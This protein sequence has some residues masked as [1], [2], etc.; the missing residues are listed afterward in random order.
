MKM[1]A[2]TTRPQDQGNTEDLP[3]L[4]G[5]WEMKRLGDIC[6]IRNQKVLPSNIDPD[7]LCVELDHIG[8]YNG[9]LLKYS[10]A[11]YSTSLKYRFFSGDIL[12]GRLRS[13]LRKF[14]HAD[15]DGICTTEIWPLVAHPEG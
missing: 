8:Q 11:Q 10:T 5:E 14:W 13:Y 3:D 1:N 12:F 4:D 9:R 7:T 2:E 15:Q 6:S